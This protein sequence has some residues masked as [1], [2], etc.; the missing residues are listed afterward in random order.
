MPLAVP[1]PGDG[2]EGGQSVALRLEG[3]QGKLTL[4]K[5]FLLVEQATA[6]SHRREREVQGC[7]KVSV[8]MLSCLPVVRESNDSEVEYEQSWEVMG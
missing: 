2:R 7:G 1:G 4:F 6:L 8:A 5:W 3:D